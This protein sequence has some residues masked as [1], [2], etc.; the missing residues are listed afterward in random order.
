MTRFAD[1]LFDDLMRE[2]GPAL[3]HTTPPA[4]PRRHSTARRTVLAGGG[5][6]A[7]AGAVAGALVAGTGTPAYAVTKNPDGTVTL[8][9]YQKSGIAGANTR[10][11]QLGD[12]QVVVVPV[13]AG[14]PRPA[15][16]AVSGRGHRITTGTSVSPDG[17]VTVNARGIPA[18]DILVVGVETSG[19]SSLTGG[20][21]T[22]APAPSCISLP[23][24][25]PGNGGSGATSGAAGGSGSNLV[26]GGAGP[27]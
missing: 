10:L 22:S 18:G 7:V 15:A 3:A 21:L 11:R 26:Q 8:A 2:H 6:L 20:I 9:V 4:Y 13:E 19:H 25:P 14:C 17:S 24:A 5:A 16:P 12:N 23:A 27:R 1:Q